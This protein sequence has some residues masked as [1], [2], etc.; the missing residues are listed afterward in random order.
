MYPKFIFHE[1]YYFTY[2]TRY[3]VLGIVN[4]NAY[5]LIL[6]ICTLVAIFNLSFHYLS[7]IS[8]L[9]TFSY[10]LSICGADCQL[11]LA[12]AKVEQIH[13]FLSYLSIGTGQAFNIIMIAW[14]SC[15]KAQLSKHKDPRR[16]SGHNYRF[17]G[18]FLQ[19]CSSFFCPHPRLS[20]LSHQILFSVALHTQIWP[21]QQRSCKWTSICPWLSCSWSE[22]CLN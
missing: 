4:M 22:I 20:C 14:C 5:M 1:F 13:K 8:T 21:V 9:L 6:Y 12:Q 10:A 19:P 15:S 18:T 16:F 7:Q 11:P 2:I 3:T 17:S